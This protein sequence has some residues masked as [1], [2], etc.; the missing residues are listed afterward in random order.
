MGRTQKASITDLPDEVIQ[1]ILYHVPATTTLSLQRTCRRFAHVANEHLLWKFYCQGTFK[2]WD[3]RHD[4]TAKLVDP[5]FIEW[6][7]LYAERYQASQATRHAVDEI[8]AQEV[9]RLDKIQTILEIGY[10]AKDVLLD[11]FLNASTSPNHLAQR[12]V[13]PNHG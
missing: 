8:V 9:G 1:A 4:L 2:W 11:A 10:D 13:N 12:C 7:K 3:G 6:K 5:S